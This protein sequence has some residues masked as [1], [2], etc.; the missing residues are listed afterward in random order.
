MLTLYRTN[1]SNVLPLTALES[2]IDSEDT[3]ICR[4]LSECKTDPRSHSCGFKDILAQLRVSEHAQNSIHLR[5]D[6]AEVL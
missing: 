5:H 4:N 3:C 2:G 1:F 6:T